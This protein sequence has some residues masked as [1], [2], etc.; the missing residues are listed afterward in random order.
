M[1]VLHLY[2]FLPR[3]PAGWR[4]FAGLTDYGRARIQSSSPACYSQAKP[5]IRRMVN[6]KVEIL[7]ARP[8][9]DFVRTAI[10]AIAA[11]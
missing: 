10:G 4:S 11:P 6:E 2:G 7:G 9:E 5:V 3:L 1:G 8:E